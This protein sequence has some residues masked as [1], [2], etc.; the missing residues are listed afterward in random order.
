M[1]SEALTAS[2]FYLLTAP[3]PATQLTLHAGPQGTQ[4][5][6]HGHASAL[7]V[8]LQSQGRSLLIDPGTYEYVGDGGNRDRFRSTAMHNTL[9][10][11]GANQAET[12]TPFS[13][14]RL[15]Q[16]KAEQ[17][18]QGR[19]FDLV[20]ASHD[21]YQRLVP[22][23][24]HRR[25]V[26]S[27]KNGVYLVRDVVEGQGQ[28][29]LDISWHLGEDLELLRENVFRV[30]G[31]SQGLALLPAQG[32]GWSEEVSKEACAPVY[33]QKAAISVLNFGTM[34]TIP[35]EFALLLVTL[36]EAHRSPGSFVRIA[37][38]QPGSA[39]SAYRYA[40]EQGECSFWFGE[41]GKAWRQGVVSSDAEFVCWIYELESRKLESH[42]PDTI[43]ILCNGSYATVDGGP[44]L[45][46]RRRVSWGEVV[47]Q[48][49]SRTVFSSDPEAMQNEELASGQLS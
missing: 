12:A 11:D 10:V 47:V 48:G 39:I 31:A 25:W 23:V 18:I 42:Q 17:W 38:P 6:G 34:T 16:S 15:T 40:S 26:F 7:S 2:G 24:T 3:Q 19:D 22:P 21:G 1:R 4:S 44:E 33:G 13:W 8:C 14:K 41:S 36:E 9:R 45:R 28:H 29:Q 32:H 27:L 46:C 5:G 30:K 35:S 49:G 20:V 37:A 43:L